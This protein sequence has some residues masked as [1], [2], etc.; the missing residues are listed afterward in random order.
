MNAL[1]ERLGRFAGRHR[2]WVVGV[3]LV[4][5][6][7]LTL[8]NRAVGGNF[9]NNYTVPGSQSANGL[10][11]LQRDFNSASGYSGQI[12]FH[13]EKGTVKD[14]ANAV[15]KTMKN[16]GGLPHVIKATDPLSVPG[17]P[18]VSKDGTIAYGTVS[19]D[20]VPA[21]LDTAYLDSLNSAVQPAES[22][23]LVVDYGGNAGQIGQ[24]PSDR[25]SET[26][27]L[28]CALILLLIMFVSIVAALIPLVGAIFS[29]GT[30]LALVG[31]LAAGPQLPT[32]A[33]TVA[34]LLGL[35]VAVDY[36]LFLVARHREQLDA[37][38]GIGDSIGRTVATSG[39]A[40][41]IA[42]STVVIAILGLYVSGVPFVGAMGA[43]AAIVVAVT[44]LSALTLVPA[45]LA[46]A[47][48]RVRKRSE[49]SKVLDAHDIERAHAAHEAS[50]FARWGRLVSRQPWPWAIGSAA[51][52]LVLAI[53]L[54]SLRLGQLDPGTD[55]KSDSDR[56]AYDLI[57]QGF[58]EGQNGPITVVL[59]LPKQSQDKTQKLLDNAT[60]TLTKTSDVASV[61]PPSV[62][63]AAT[64]A[65]IN[66][67]PKSSPQAQRT[68]DLVDH[69]RDSV[70]PTLGATS[71][72]LVGTTAG[73]VD[74]T[75][76]IGERMI[77]L[78]LAV[79]LLSFVLL[80][81][82]FRSIV[83]S[84]KAAILNLLSVGAAYGVVVAVFQWG[85]GSQLL[86]IDQDLPIPAYVP[87]L[88]FAIVFG[89]SMDYEVFLLSRV[90]EAWHQTGDAHRAVAIGIGSTARVITSAAAIMVVVF[91]SFVLNSNPAVKML[92]VGMAVA[93]L[94]DASVVRMVL[95]P[96]LMSILGAHAWWLP[97][98]LD[99]VIPDLQ[100][101]G[102]IEPVPATEPESEPVAGAPRP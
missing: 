32:T 52:L 12:V 13:A 89:L 49:R 22:A 7:G 45:F 41:V 1:L 98:W 31:L 63:K 15:A 11:A 57:S 39:A 61:A 27:G 78:I 99:R 18:A 76:R 67:I 47:R 25:R 9:V 102:P 33:P 21:S 20:V 59:K 90:R 26:L 88:M 100:L 46:I 28:V 83:I 44:M 6:V 91:S 4:V 24:E 97:R 74:F 16:V 101:E 81:I 72:Y 2:W 55:P 8:T 51:L 77:W 82:A 80:T 43:A 73:N 19:W 17:T 86:G 92:A 75:Q 38:M 79:V 29:V 95:V 84:V 68:T 14:Q 69:L 53:P 93:V 56:R 10:E 30:G 96:A 70:L 50:A 23:G 54:L 71:T 62:N 48:N 3:W 58:G 94:I 35:G 66:V 64:V 40:V 37:G 85:W 60:S 5:L 87:M 42:G 36:G 34:T 65:V